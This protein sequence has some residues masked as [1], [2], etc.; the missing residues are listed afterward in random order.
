M[1]DLGIG[2]WGDEPTFHAP[3][4]VVTH[5]AAETIVER[6][7]A[8]YARADSGARRPQPPRAVSCQPAVGP[9]T[10]SAVAP[11]GSGASVNVGVGAAAGAGV[12]LTAS[13]LRA[14]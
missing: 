4:F 9:A 12:T 6:G 1:A 14:R 10:T 13:L 11:L 5:R 7:G 3:L 2:P 8:S